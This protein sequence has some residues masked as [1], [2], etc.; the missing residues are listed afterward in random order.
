LINPDGIIIARD[1]R[2]EELMQKL[3]EEINKKKEKPNI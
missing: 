2:G 1:L 3:E